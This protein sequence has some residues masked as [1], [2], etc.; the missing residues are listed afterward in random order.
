[1]RI[2]LPAGLA[3]AVAAGAIFA[4]CQLAGRGSA[5]VTGGG[6]YLEATVTG[7]QTLPEA[8]GRAPLR[9]STSVLRWWHGD[10]NHGRWEIENRSPRLDAVTLT[11]VRDGEYEWIYDSSSW[12]YK[13]LP[14]MP[15]PP[16]VSVRHP[17][18]SGW[19]GPAPAPASDVPAL[20]E[21]L[22]DIPGIGAEARIAGERQALGRRAVII[23]YGRP[24]GGE[25]ATLA[26]D[27]E[28][29]FILEYEFSALGVAAGREVVTL[30]RSGPWPAERYRFRPPPGVR[31]ALSA[32]SRSGGSESHTPAGT[33][34]V[35]DGFLRPSYL[36]AGYAEAT[37]GYQD[38]VAGGTVAVELGFTLGRSEDAP[39]LGIQERL[40]RDGLP[41][42]L[43]KGKRSGPAGEYWL[44][45]EP[46]LTTL[47]FARS[48]VGVLISSNRLDGRELQRVADAMQPQP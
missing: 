40:R 28:T 19:V 26:V 17:A 46:G 24:G 15:A 21:Y 42:G 7:T 4:Q 33:V 6:F 5:D 36:P 13:R 23:E 27:P 39:Y 14:L 37:A 32:T 45:E 31:Q 35:P 3:I 9:Q 10:A 1:M 44:V 8:P 43:K 38:G 48:G 12:F 20:L 2:P 34:F 47:A 41:D 11:I 22:R 25:V 16:G 18:V 30:L 29:M